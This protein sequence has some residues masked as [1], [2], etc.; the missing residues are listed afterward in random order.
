MRGD[1]F[2][3]SAHTSCSAISPRLVA[4]RPIVSRIRQALAMPCHTVHFGDSGEF[5]D[6][7][8]GSPHRPAGYWSEAANLMANSPVFIALSLDLLLE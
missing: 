8:H 4:W 2:L 5:G 6:Q 7:A 1:F 3:S